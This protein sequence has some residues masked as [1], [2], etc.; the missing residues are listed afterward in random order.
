[1]AAH[2]IPHS[3][4]YK[5]L[6]ILRRWDSG[7]SR[8]HRYVSAPAEVHTAIEGGTVTETEAHTEWSKRVLTLIA[9]LVVVIV[10]LGVTTT[11]TILQSPDS[12]PLDC[13]SGNLTLTG[14]TAFSAVMK[15]A[16]ESYRKT[17]RERNSLSISTAAI[18]DCRS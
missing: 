8:F 7:G 6:A 9:F 12:A 11:V 3:W 5:I 1:M 13:A 15:D 10:G 18:P 14:S 2:V 4:H 16:A 17:C